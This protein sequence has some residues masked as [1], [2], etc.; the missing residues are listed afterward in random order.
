MWRMLLAVLAAPNCR[1]SRRG[2]LAGTRGSPSKNGLTFASPTTRA[3]A[4]ADGILLSS[5]ASVAPL[6]VCGGRS[7]LSRALYAGTQVLFR[8]PTTLSS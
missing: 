6:M 3:L 7:A 1:K 4:K 2:R 5:R 8:S